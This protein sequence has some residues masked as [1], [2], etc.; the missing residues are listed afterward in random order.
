MNNIPDNRID[1]DKHPFCSKRPKKWCGSTHCIAAITA[2]RRDEFYRYKDIC[3]TVCMGC[4]KTY[5]GKTYSGKFIQ[6]NIYRTYFYYMNKRTI[7]KN[8]SER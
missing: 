8:L 6:S 1:H 3:D 7:D 4:I 2:E 5:S